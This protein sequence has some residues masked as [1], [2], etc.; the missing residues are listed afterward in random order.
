M[1]HNDRLQMLHEKVVELHTCKA[2]LTVLGHHWKP[3]SYTIIF[4]GGCTAHPPCSSGTNKG[5]C[6]ACHFDFH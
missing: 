6:K 3:A 4:Q 1:N 2:A 5:S